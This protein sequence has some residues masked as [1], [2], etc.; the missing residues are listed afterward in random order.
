MGKL[1]IGNTDEEDKSSLDI[2]NIEVDEGGMGT[3]LELTFSQDLTSRFNQNNIKLQSLSGANLSGK[4]GMSVSRPSNRPNY[5]SI[6]LRRVT[7][8]SGD[9]RITIET[10]DSED[11]PVKI[12][13]EFTVK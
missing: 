12:V 11:K 9:Y 6:E 13:K 7:L 4:I 8:S 10:Y 2:I 1:H 3:L 5:A